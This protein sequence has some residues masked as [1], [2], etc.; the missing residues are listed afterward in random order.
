MDGYSEIVLY[1]LKKKLD[2]RQNKN[3][4][5][6]INFLKYCGGRGCLF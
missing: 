6:Q 3:V 4:H 1:C 2:F 5:I